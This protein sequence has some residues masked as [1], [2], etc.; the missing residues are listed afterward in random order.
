MME[1][2]MLDST[3]ARALAEQAASDQWRA[4][5]S[6]WARQL[7][8]NEIVADPLVQQLVRDLSLKMAVKRLSP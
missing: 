4:E 3:E 7:L 8:E 1:E 5:R 6:A 2:M